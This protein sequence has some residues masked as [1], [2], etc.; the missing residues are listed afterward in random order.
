MTPDGLSSLA[1]TEYHDSYVKFV[2]ISDPPTPQDAHGCPTSAVAP[3][4][5]LTSDSHDRGGNSRTLSWLACLDQAPAKQAAASHSNAKAS[6]AAVCRPSSESTQS[7]HRVNGAV[8]EL[9]DHRDKAGLGIPTQSAHR[10]N[11][12]VLSSG[13]TA[14]KPQTV[15]KGCGRLVAGQTAGDGGWG[16]LGLEAVL[17][18]SVGCAGRAPEQHDMGV[19]EKSKGKRRSHLDVSTVINTVINTKEKDPE[20]VELLTGDEG[21]WTPFFTDR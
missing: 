14:A 21:T 3:L 7:A 12:G 4:S 9:L 11:G 19:R 15:K 8:G 20:K 10:V 2:P 18:G 5:W 1:Q 16:G 13:D 17:G 6:A